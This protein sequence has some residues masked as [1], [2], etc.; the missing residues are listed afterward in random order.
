MTTSL[1]QLSTQDRARVN[2]AYLRIIFRCYPA[3]RKHITAVSKLISKQKSPRSALQH[4]I[5]QHIGRPAAFKV[6]E[7]AVKAVVEVVFKERVMYDK[8]QH[9]TVCHA[10][11]SY[12][13]QCKCTCCG[14]FRF[15][16]GCIDYGDCLN[17][18]KSD[19]AR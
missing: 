14:Q 8:E 12:C 19:G 7:L 6:K 1:S 15:C 11:Y 13:P 3:L 4:V 17:C 10:C 18:A 16:A 5:L 9:N 2:R